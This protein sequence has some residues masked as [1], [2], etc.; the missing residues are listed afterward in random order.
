MRKIITRRVVS[1]GLLLQWPPVLP[2]HCLTLKPTFL[3][4]G[5]AVNLR[6]RLQVHTYGSLGS[7]PSPW[8][9]KYTEDPHN[10]VILI[11]V[12]YEDRRMLGVAEPTLIEAYQPIYNRKLR[13]GFGFPEV[14]A[15]RPPDQT[16]DVDELCPKR[17]LGPEDVKNRPGI[18]LWWIDPGDEL[19]SMATLLP[20]MMRDAYRTHPENPIFALNKKGRP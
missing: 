18:Y 14:W 15:L 17:R 11:S 8:I 5:R 12:W 20:Q 6:N 1:D 9:D 19:N 13:E 10:H 7:H 2:C 4:A 16:T 3:Y